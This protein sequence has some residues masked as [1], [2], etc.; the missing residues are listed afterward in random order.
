MTK[1][2][3]INKKIVN[4]LFTSQKPKYTTYKHGRGTQLE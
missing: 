3:M 1:L 4:H 2:Q